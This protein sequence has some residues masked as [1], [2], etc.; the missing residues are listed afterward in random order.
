MKQNSAD[1]EARR[2]A[3]VKS[4]DILDTAAESDYDDLVKLAALIFH[5]PISTV[6]IV[7]SHRQWFKAAIGLS[8]KE[9]DRNIS[10]CTHVVDQNQNLVVENTS[11]DPR[12]ANNPLV[13]HEPKLGFYAGV[14]LRTSDNSAIG[15]F[16][17]MD[18]YP[19]IPPM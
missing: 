4:A 3:A 10:F 8:I 18:K 12:F 13:V 6:T 14:P 17:I 1:Y 15:T 11:H 5:V 9:T 19:R 7:D 2:L 16:C